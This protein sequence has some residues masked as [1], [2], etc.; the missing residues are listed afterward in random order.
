[1]SNM[2]APRVSVLIPCYNAGVF[3]AQA[4]QSV[5]A[6]TFQDFEIVVV[7]DG[8]T[9]DSAAVAKGFDAVRYVCKPHSGISA[10]R[11]MAIAQAKGEFLAFLDA[12]D[13]WHPE[14]LQKQVA[15]LDANPQCQ[16]VHCHAKNFF[17]GPQEQMTLR[18]KQLMEANLE[19]YMASSCIRRTVFEKYGSFR[20]DLAVGEDTH[21]IARLRAAGVDMG[22]CIA[23]ELY[24]RRI[25]CSNISLSHEKVDRKDMM[26]LLADAIRQRNKGSKG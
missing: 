20:E 24:F 6:Q 22:H 8:S 25:H 23:E 9:D 5:L 7:D 21:W 14:K 18:Q 12:D 13:L 11:N 3:L 26:A 19:N 1:M 15:H 16:L 10:T 2:D 17:D 4:I